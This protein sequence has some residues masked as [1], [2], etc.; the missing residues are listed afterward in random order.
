VL[1]G[2]LV[3]S[4]GCAD[5]L[6]GD[7]PLEYAA[8]EVSVSEE[9][10]AAAGFVESQNRTVNL[11]RTVEFQNESRELRISNHASVYRKSGDSSGPAPIAVAVVATPQAETLGVALNPV[12]NMPLDRVVTFASEAGADFGG[13]LDSLSRDGTWQATVLGESREITRFTAT[14]TTDDGQTV[15]AYLHVLKVRHDGDFVLAAAATPQTLQDSGA[16]TR[17]QFATMF[18]GVQH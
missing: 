8:S 12:Q 10:R 3:L 17:A 11:N 16:V 6:T 2:L 9:N 5:F 14:V 15:D 7:G 4:A 18:E 13:T 1:V